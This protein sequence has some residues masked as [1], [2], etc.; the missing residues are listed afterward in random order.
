MSTTKNQ[1]KKTVQVKVIYRGQVHYTTTVK[2]DYQLGHYQAE[3]KD[4]S[5][6]Q[7]EG[8]IYVFQKYDKLLCHGMANISQL[9][10]N[11]LFLIY[12]KIYFH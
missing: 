12:K 6:I 2:M 11:F 5:Q 9:Q 4:F 7:C 3:S 8:R 1:R 10:T